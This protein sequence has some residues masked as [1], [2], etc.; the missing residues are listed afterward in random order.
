MKFSK[1]WLLLIL[2]LPIGIWALQEWQF[3]KLRRFCDEIKTGDAFITIR[4]DAEEKGLSP[5]IDPNHQ[6]RVLPLVFLPGQTSETCRIFFNE[7]YRT[8]EYRGIQ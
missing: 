2:I 4:N 1:K 8:V 5:V 6:I 7:K 3:Y